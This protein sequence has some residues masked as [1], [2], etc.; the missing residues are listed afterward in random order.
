MSTPNPADRTETATPAAR[1]GRRLLPWLAPIALFLIAYVARDVRLGSFSWPDEVTWTARSVAFYAGLAGGDLEATH[2]SDHPGVVP[3]WGYGGLLS[4]QALLRGNVAE[5]YTMTTERELQDIP[6][7]LATE[8]L[9]TV[10]ITSLTVVGVYLLLKR[11]LDARVGF[12]AALMVALDPFY[13][14]HSRVV[15]VDAILTSFMTLSA[16]ALAVYLVRPTRKRYLVLSAVTGGLAFAT[17]SP[18][19]VLAPLVLG[20][21]LLRVILQR[22]APRG[23]AGG[24]PGRRLLWAVLSLA[25]WL[26]ITW[27]TFLAVWPA[28]WMKPLELTSLVLL[29]SR[30]GVVTSHQ[31]N[32]FMGQVT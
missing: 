17:K 6:G 24:P 20:G 32:Y 21:L 10:L 14:V 5:L 26:A 13:L 31:F 29:G 18:A 22:D 2:Q 3:M 27:A 9:W 16:L 23:W 1:R 28:A 25:G 4:L 7:M 12:L 8:A 19:V 11:V 15:H 30:W